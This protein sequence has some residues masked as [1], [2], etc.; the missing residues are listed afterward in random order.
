VKRRRVPAAGKRRRR[1]RPD[2][3]RA[4]IVAA[5]IDE[6][7]ARGYDAAST[8]AIADAARV[9][10]GLVFHHFDSKA[11]LYVEVISQLCERLIA[12][13]LD[14]AQS[15]PTDLFERLYAFS[16]HKIRAFQRDLP[17]YRVLAQLPEAPAP[18]RVAI[19][20]KAAE[21]RAALWPIL[22]RGVDA[23]R[24]RPGLSLEDAIDTILVLND[25]LERRLI[26]RIRELPD[27][28]LAEMEDIFREV[29]PHFERLRDGLYAPTSS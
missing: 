6:F 26:A 14:V 20:A 22:L 4:R 24:L 17:S 2:D 28:G 18:L 25:G 7:G 16:M 1:A 9:A 5:A 8:N 29:W 27:H 23:S 21:V 12:S 19:F 11:A 13:Y 10:K 15:W 3:A